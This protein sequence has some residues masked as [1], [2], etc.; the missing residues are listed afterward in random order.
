M[1]VQFCAPTT[2]STVEGCATVRRDGKARS[3][4]F[5]STTV[6]LQTAQDMVA[7][8]GVPASASRVGKVQPATSVGFHIIY[9]HTE[10]IIQNFG[11]EIKYIEGVS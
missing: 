2:A 1:C 8:S 11:L 3:V 6:R 5:P 7:A 10:V 9:Y 4:T